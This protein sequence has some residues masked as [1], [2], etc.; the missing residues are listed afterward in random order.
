MSTMQEIHGQ[1]MQ[2][3]SFKKPASC[4]PLRAILVFTYVP[5]SLIVG[6]ALTLRPKLHTDYTSFACARNFP[7]QAPDINHESA[8]SV[9]DGF[10]MLCGLL[11]DA[12]GPRARRPWSL[13]VALGDRTQ[14]LSKENASQ[15]TGFSPPYFGE[16]VSVGIAAAVAIKSQLARF[17]HV[18]PGSVFVHVDE[19]PVDTPRQRPRG[20]E[21]GDASAVHVLQR[22]FD[23]HS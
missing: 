14:Q 19:N 9:R 23:E 21:Q 8:L 2:T 22:R 17:V 4:Q 1:S 12:Q 5:H 20:Q 10:H 3:M 16:F 7:E 18:E 13:E 15:C 11:P 6:N